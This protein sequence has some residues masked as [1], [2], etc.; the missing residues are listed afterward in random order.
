[1]RP[2]SAAVFLRYA[3]SLDFVTEI[4]LL[5]H[6][7]GGVIAGML[8]GYYHDVVK[9]LVMLAPAATLKSDAQEG[10]CFRATYDPQRVPESVC[11]DG[12]H[13][14]G[15]LYFRMAQ[16]LPIY[17]VTARFDGPMLVVFGQ[18]DQLVSLDAARRYMDGRTQRRLALYESL[19]HGLQGADHTR[20]LADIAAFLSR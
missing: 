15:G 18:K 14:V 8:S 17:E 4:N 10:H 13:E 11:V 16:T 5:G 12:V 7:Q 2:V 6:S 9:R 20:M 1:M 19:D 3:R